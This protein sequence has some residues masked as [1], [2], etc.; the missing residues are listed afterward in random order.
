[1]NSCY[2]S[3]CASSGVVGPHNHFLRAQKVEGGKVT[4][5]KLLATE[6]GHCGRTGHTARYCGEVRDKLQQKR[7]TMLKNSQK[8]LDRGDWMPTGKVR[9]Q[10][11][12]RGNT[13]PASNVQS[14]SINLAKG[15]FA[16]DIESDDEESNIENPN[17][18]MTWAQVTRG[19]PKEV[20]SDDELPPLNWGKVN[21][22]RWS[23]MA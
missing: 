6:C 10:S 4:C 17:L 3:F 19:V 8:A 13:L 12:R 15:F 23:D 2:C 20:D 5:P 18:D 11:G 7:V 9:A 16:L 14:Q 22:M 21:S 1:M